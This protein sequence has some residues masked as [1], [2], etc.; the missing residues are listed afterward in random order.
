MI[1][2]L[3]LGI[4]SILYGVCIMRIASGT[5][6]FSVWYAIGAAWILLGILIRSHKLA[7]LPRAVKIAAA[8]LIAAGVVVICACL[9]LIGTHF[10]DKGNNNLDCI[11]VLGAQVKMPAGD[12]AWSESQKSASD[13]TDQAAPGNG[14]DERDQTGPV[15]DS[16]VTRSTSA[17]PSTVLKYRLD[18]AAGYLKDNPDTV[19]IVSGGQ[20]SSEPE[21]EAVVMKR[22]LVGCG[23]D[24]SR[25]LTEDQSSSTVENITYSRK[26]LEAYL[27]EHPELSVGI[28][29]NNFHVYRGCAIARKVFS[30]HVT[31]PES[32]SDTG[33]SEG[34]LSAKSSPSIEISGIAAPS[35]AFYLPNNCLREC[36]GIVKDL[37]KGNL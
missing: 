28:V 21:P 1:I 19:C 2:C 6:F 32:T 16:P 30:S 7:L 25:I 35:V 14:S 11:V 4:L 29:T 31:P 22:Y 12:T 36:M 15:T 20:S 17:V 5:L 3:I 10:H 8:V 18:T 13:Y 9:F 27:A 26:V 37:V 23:I 33:D 24:E 34:P